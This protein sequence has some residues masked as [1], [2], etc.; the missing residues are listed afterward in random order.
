MAIVSANSSIGFQG[1]SAMLTFIEG[2]IA[3]GSY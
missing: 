1:M 3:L 2:R